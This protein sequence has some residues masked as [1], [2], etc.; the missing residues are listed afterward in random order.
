MQLRHH[1]MYLSVLAL[2]FAFTWAWISAVEHNAKIMDSEIQG[3]KATVR[4]LQQV[5][6]LPNY[7][8]LPMMNETSIDGNPRKQPQPFKIAAGAVNGIATLGYSALR[9]LVGVIIGLVNDGA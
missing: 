3:L 2:M 1:I 5:H 9:S 8:L 4:R 7:Q 6:V